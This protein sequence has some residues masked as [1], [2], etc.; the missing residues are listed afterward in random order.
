[1][2]PMRRLLAV[3]AALIVLAAVPAW[4]VSNPQNAF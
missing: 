1:M 4:A 3:L 2:F